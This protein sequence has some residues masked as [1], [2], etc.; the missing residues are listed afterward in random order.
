MSKPI[1]KTQFHK[2]SLVESVSWDILTNNGAVFKRTDKW[3]VARFDGASNITWPNRSEL[4]IQDQLSLVW[5]VKSNDDSTNVAIMGQ[6]LDS[7]NRNFSFFANNTFAWNKPRMTLIFGGNAPAVDGNFNICDWQR[8][9][10][11]GTYDGSIMKMYVDGILQNTESWITWVNINNVDLDLKIGSQEG[12]HYIDWDIPDCLIYN[13]ALTQTEIN[14]LYTD[15]LSRKPLSVQKT[16][17]PWIKPTRINDES[18]V[19]WYNMIPS[20]GWVLTDISNNG[21]NAT[22]NWPISSK[23]WLRFDWVDDDISTLNATEWFASSSV[24]TLIYN[25][26]LIDNWLAQRLINFEETASDFFWS[27]INSTEQFRFLLEYD[28]IRQFLITTGSDINIYNRDITIIIVQDWTWPKVYIDGEIYTNISYLTENDRT[29]WLDWLS[30]T[31]SDIN[32]GNTIFSTNQYFKWEM[33]DIRYYSRVFTEQQIKEYHN[34]RAS[35]Y[36]L[37]EDFRYDK[38]DW[39]NVTPIDRIKW[40][41]DYKIVENAWLDGKSKALEC[42]SDWYISR[43]SRQAY[44]TWEFGLNKIW[45]NLVVVPFIGNKPIAFNDSNFDWYLFAIST[46]NFLTIQRRS[47]GSITAIFRTT[48]NFITSWLDYNYKIIRYNNWDFEL[49]VKW[50]EYWESYTLKGSGNDNT[51]NE[52][53]YFIVDN[54]IWDQISNISIKKGIE[55]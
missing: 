41:W 40:T 12:V 44:W 28:W 43:Q 9:M 45:S 29:A 48:R 1:F 3:L 55:V 31:S 36:Y 25:F 2:G 21:Y 8:H 54:D 10:V 4:D 53:N 16:N 18:L 46:S 32:I 7:A 34:Y 23:N 11:V 42:T 49:Y 38:K 52:S 13:Y 35:Q 37:Y 14:D 30:W 50:Q 26:K 27:F 24:G 22:I 15:F 33:Y 51:Y 20:A 17:F 47:W 5:F 6:S 39:N 19:F